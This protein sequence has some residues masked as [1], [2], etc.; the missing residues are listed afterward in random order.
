MSRIAR[1]DSVAVASSSPGKFEMTKAVSQD[2]GIEGLYW[3]W[4]EIEGGLAEPIKRNP[5][6]V[7]IEKMM[8]FAPNI[9]NALSNLAVMPDRVAIMD[10][11]AVV[12]NLPKMTEEQSVM[13]KPEGMS[14][15]DAFTTFFALCRD[16][17]V[18][19]DE[20]G[21]EIEIL[22]IAYYLINSTAPVDKVKRKLVIKSKKAIEVGYERVDFFLNKALVD[23]LADPDEIK[24]LALE[25][26]PIAQMLTTS[27]V[28]G[29]RIQDL[30]PLIVEVASKKRAD[31]VEMEVRGDKD[32]GN[33]QVQIDGMCD[34]EQEIEVGLVESDGSKK[35][36]PFM[37]YIRWAVKN[38]TPWLVE[39]MYTE[40]RKKKR[41]VAM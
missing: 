9:D 37:Q 24:Q 35:T 22:E 3:T 39:K 40:K 25:Y 6:D 4:L 32:R 14:A 10:V 18:D 8:M 1:Y 5:K 34:L 19:G 30:I 23:L 11:L 7:G 21:K 36:V 26:F 29:F 31:G 17:M 20:D 41:E 15:L 16:Q 33:W 38:V 27:S 12:Q 13:K 28:V 2:L